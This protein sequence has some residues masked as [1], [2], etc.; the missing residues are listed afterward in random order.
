MR[1]LRIV[2]VVGVMLVNVASAVPVRG[3]DLDFVYIAN[4]GN[5]ADTQ[6]M[7]DDT[8]GYGAVSNNYYI[9]KYEVTNSQWNAFVSEVGAPIGTGY[10]ANA[11]DEEASLYTSDLQPANKVSW[12]ETLQFCNYLTTGDKSQGV[13]IFNGNN[14]NP[15]EFMGIND[16]L[17]TGLTPAYWLP[18]EDEWY[19]AA[20]F[21]PDGSGYSLYA[22]GT[23]TMPIAGVDSN[24][25]QSLPYSG[26][27]NIYSGSEEQN[28]TFNMMGNVWEWNETNCIAAL[29]GM[30]GGTFDVF[31][32][33]ASD[34]RAQ[35]L[36]PR[37]EYD[38]TGFRIATNVP[39]PAT[40]LL[41][42]LGAVMIR[43]KR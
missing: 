36:N 38:N 18:T 23:D 7:D 21:K 17:K 31:T 1:I 35:Y 9:G 12:F 30:R 39:E 37:T 5:V 22:N 40:L 3:I 25:N 8:S 15:G 2:L 33:P 19:K 29:R 16:S 42:T 13:Y 14:T 24:Y 41:L 32:G 20:Y 34:A 11:Y 26:P 10:W 43:R 27:W 6:I 28:G 4:A